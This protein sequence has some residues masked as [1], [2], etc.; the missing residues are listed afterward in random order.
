MDDALSLTLLLQCC[1]LLSRLFERKEV[2][3][4]TRPL[5]YLYLQSPG[6][7]V[8]FLEIFGVAVRAQD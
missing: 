6:L 3:C 7:L 1:Q 4:D 8:Q 5:Y 2:I